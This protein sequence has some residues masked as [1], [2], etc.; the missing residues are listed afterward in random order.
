LLTVVYEPLARIQKEGELG[1]RK[2]TQ[3]TRYMTVILGAL[4]SIGIAAI[5][6]KQGLVLNPGIGFS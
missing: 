1:R 6:T 5:L 4:Q 3:W 2:I